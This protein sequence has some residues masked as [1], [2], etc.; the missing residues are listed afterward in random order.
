MHNYNHIPI[1]EQKHLSSI[2]DKTGEI[3]SQDKEV[4][5]SNDQIKTRVSVFKML[6]QVCVLL[7]TCS[8]ASDGRGW[9]IVCVFFLNN[10]ILYICCLLYIQYCKKKKSH[11]FHH[12]FRIVSIVSGDIPGYSKGL[13]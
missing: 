1:K 8:A 11:N 13:S 9:A 6:H 12:T 2:T 10:P 5:L 4:D 7:F 3:F